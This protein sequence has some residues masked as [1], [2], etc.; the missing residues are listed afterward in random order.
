MKYKPRYLGSGGLN[1][2][3]SQLDPYPSSELD[4]L[5]FV[6]SQNRNLV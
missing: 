3:L 1:I 4:P 6:E 5:F 2:V